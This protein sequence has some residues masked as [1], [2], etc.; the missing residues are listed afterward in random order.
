MLG[1]FV[2]SLPDLGVVGFV[3]AG[4][5]EVRVGG[6]EPDRSGPA[7]QCGLDLFRCRRSRG[8]DGFDGFGGLFGF[9]SCDHDGLLSSV[10]W[11]DKI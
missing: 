3:G 10:G 4:V 11:S 9:G 8:F 2:Q 6:E 7:S 5:G 1:S